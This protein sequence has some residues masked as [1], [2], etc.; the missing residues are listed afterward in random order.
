MAAQA[1]MSVGKTCIVIILYSS[2]MRRNP[3]L[4]MTKWRLHL[5]MTAR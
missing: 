5:T 1:E 2:I 4:L 3:Y